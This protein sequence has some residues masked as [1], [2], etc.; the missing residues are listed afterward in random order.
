MKV[1]LAILVLVVAA[2]VVVAYFQFRGPQEKPV[3]YVIENIPIPD[4]IELE[5]GGMAFTKDDKLG[6][7]TRHGE[8][9]VLENPYME[10]GESPVFR[11]FA[12]GL[13]EALGLAVSDH[14][15]LLSQRG[16]LTQL[17]DRDED[18]QAERYRAIYSWPLSGNY[19]EYSYGPV[20][21]R[22]STMLVT[23]NLSWIGRGESLAKWRGWLLN[24][25][26][27]GAMT[28][29]A[30]GLRSPAGLAVN[31]DGDI[32]YT[33][34]Q[35][36]WVGSGRLTHLQKGDFAG[37]PAGLKW[38]GEPNSPLTLKRQDVPNTG[39]PL[40]DVAAD[41]PALKIPAVWFPQGL[42]GV[43]TSDI[44]ID[45]TA[46]GFGPFTGQMFVGD[47]GHS[48]VMRVFMEKVEG[49]YQ[50]VCFPFMEGFSSG[51]FRLKWGS[52][53]SMFV[54]MTSR[55]WNSTGPQMFGLQRLR[56]T[57]EVPFEI[58]NIRVKPDGFLLEFTKP[59]DRDSTALT[60]AYSVTGFT[61]HY[62]SRY[63]SAVM[64]QQACM[65]HQVEISP[66]GMSAHL[67]VH[68][69]RKG[70]IHEIKAAGVRSEDG[71]PL[72]HDVGYYTLNNVPGGK[73]SHGS[74][75]SQQV[76]SKEAGDSPKHPTTRPASW[77]GA[78]VQALTVGT[79]PGLQFD[80]AEIKVKAGSKIALTFNN[81]DDMLHNM[82]LTIPG[83]A[84]DKVGKMAL[85]MGLKGPEMNWVPVSEQVLFHTSLL[86]PDS[87]ETI[88]FEAPAAGVYP[89][90]CTFPGHYLV[91]RGKLI[92]E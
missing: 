71:L 18:G 3:Y 25:K 64:N 80:V 7:S 61:Y 15:F 69:L 19:H 82:V 35:G 34:N 58:K 12:S 31:G 23:L 78:D 20:L 59:V 74:A 5:V 85:E 32:F 53:N 72:L 22:D 13:H 10:E 51:V 84:V 50:G 26:P 90:I 56:W 81:N 86:Q 28:P 67:I 40:F 54:G 39:L 14:G 6:I 75:T 63:G 52:D 89:F 38:S 70:Y 45:T 21:M 62:W 77:E 17:V 83:D 1:K 55:G 49:E 87:R 60:S 36:D 30:T 41:L 57:G 66:D 8:V 11:K 24:I 47:Q 27:D 46:G 33:E 88:Y 29:I 91:M 73:I 48:K 42:M 68:G 76:A 65:V 92:V 37:N 16:E 43:S 79:K 9:W 44:L 4:S 2:V